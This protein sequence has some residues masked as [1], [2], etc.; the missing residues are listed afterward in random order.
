MIVSIINDCKD[1]NAKGRQ[2]AR[3]GSLFLSPVNFVSV[4]ND[5]EASGNLVDLLDAYQDN[6]GVILLNVAPRNGKAKKWKNGTPFGYFYFKNVLIVSSVDGFCLSLAKKFELFEKI[7]VIDFKKAVFEMSEKGFLSKETEKYLLK[8]QFRSY[9]F[10]PLVASYLLK[11]EKIASFQMPA[12]DIEDM[13]KN[14]W[15]IDNF[16][17][18]KTSIL[19]EDVDLSDGFFHTKKGSFKF[20]ESLKDVPDGQSAVVVGSSGMSKKRFLEIVVQ[21]GSAQKEFGFEV[22]DIIID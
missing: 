12:S 14:I 9:E 17:N 4:K 1:E 10:L 18:C 8:T 11:N 15:W 2:V 6:K 13:K 5:I 7:N 3:A 19:K 21:G 22:S 20:F 16:G